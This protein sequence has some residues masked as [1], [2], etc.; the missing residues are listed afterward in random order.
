MLHCIVHSVCSVVTKHIVICQ[1]WH[2]RN[3]KFDEKSSEI[4]PMSMQVASPYCQLQ[5]VLTTNNEKLVPAV[6]RLKGSPD[7]HLRKKDMW[8]SLAPSHVASHTSEGGRTL[9]HH[10]YTNQ[11]AVQARQAFLTIAVDMMSRIELRCSKDG[12]YRL[13]YMPL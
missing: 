4:F 12:I 9:H 8:F 2:V 5:A 1:S 3:S 6:V 10:I 7:T 13:I 11:S